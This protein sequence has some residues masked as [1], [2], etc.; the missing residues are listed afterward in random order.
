MSDTK[1]STFSPATTTLDELNLLHSKFV[2]QRSKLNFEILAV[3]KT[4]ELIKN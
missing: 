3:V 4:I 1:T 2:E